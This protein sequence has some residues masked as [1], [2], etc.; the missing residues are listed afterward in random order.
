MV[1][2]QMNTTD[3]L[4]EGKCLKEKMLD[5]NIVGFAQYVYQLYSPK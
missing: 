1:H 4:L 2:R 3:P 5:S